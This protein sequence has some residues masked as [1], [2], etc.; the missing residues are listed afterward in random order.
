[1]LCFYKRGS[2]LAWL[3]CGTVSSGMEGSGWARMTLAEG[4]EAKKDKELTLFYPDY[5]LPSPNTILEFL[6]LLTMVIRE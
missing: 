3:P 4:L 1:M 2:N 6:N 5:I